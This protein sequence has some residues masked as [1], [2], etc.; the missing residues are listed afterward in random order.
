MIAKTVQESPATE[1]ASFP[2]WLV[3]RR[4]T[5]DDYD[6]M[7]ETGMIAAD[8]R[9]ELLDGE[10]VCQMPINARHAG[11]VNRLNRLL[12]GQVVD[13]AIVAVQNPVRLD[14][15]SEPQPDVA[16]LRL[17]DDSYDQSHPGPEDVLLL[18]EV[19]DSSLDLDRRVKVPL[20][21]AAGIA[22]VWLVDLMN[23]SVEV[24]RDPDA[25]GYRQ[26]RR[27]ER[28]SVLS[29]MSLPELQL[30]VDEVLGAG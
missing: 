22:E 19:A 25:R 10:V 11:C 9:T 4:F 1:V 16:L 5:A 17:R 14:P 8:E 6:R 18:I 2:L 29:P 26:L 21:A 3:R 12:G 28:G 23:A 7:G 27:S 20:Y 24:Y 15:F 30:S 13:R